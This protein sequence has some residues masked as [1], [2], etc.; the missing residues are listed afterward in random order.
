MERLHAWSPC[1]VVQVVPCTRAPGRG[2]SPARIS[3]TKLWALIWV[4]LCL[5]EGA[6]CSILTKVPYRQGWS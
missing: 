3:L 6:P 1:T 2:A 4:C 5:E